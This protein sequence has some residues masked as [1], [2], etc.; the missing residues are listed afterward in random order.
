MPRLD[1]RLCGSAF[2]VHAQALTPDINAVDH[3]EEIVDI[4][5]YLPI[6]TLGVAKIRIDPNL[7][8]TEEKIPDIPLRRQDHGT[9]AQTA[10][11]QRQPAVM[12]HEGIS[13]HLYQEP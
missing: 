13:D 10:T 11:E 4:N 12:G 3:R 1:A 5:P 9:Y 7:R 6:K 8:E 2:F